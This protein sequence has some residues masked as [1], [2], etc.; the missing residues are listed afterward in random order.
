MPLTIDPNDPRLGHGVDSEPRPKQE[1]YF[2]LSEAERAKGFVRPVRLSYKHVGPQGPKYALRDLTDEEKKLWDNEFA[3][4]EVYPESK[5]PAV[6]RFW[7]QAELDSIGKGCGSVT[8]MAQVIA[9][10]YARSPNLY[11]STYCVVCQMHLPVAE[12]VWVDDGTIV[13]S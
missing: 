3:K 5:S 2:V 6:G 1:R 12:F 11:G 10:T 9:E 4:F 13:G 7:T 8:T